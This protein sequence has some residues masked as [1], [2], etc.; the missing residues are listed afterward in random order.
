MIV[1]D[2]AHIITSTLTNLL[3][4]IRFD[5]WVIS[6]TGSTDNTK[7]LITEFFQKEGIPGTL[8]DTPWTDFG[9]NRTAVLDAAF[10]KA[11]YGLM[12]DA[13]DDIKGDFRLPNPLTMDWYNLQY[14]YGT[15][16][17]LTRPQLFNLRKRWRY[18]GVLHEY[19]EPVD[20]VG[21]CSTI[22]GPYYFTL[23]YRGNRS[24]DADKYI[25]DAITLELAF[26]KTEPKNPLHSRYAY[27]CAQSYHCANV[28]PKAIEY[29]KKT[30][31]LNGWSEEKYVSSFRLYDL[32]DNKMT[33][34]FYL[35]DALKYNPKRIECVYRLVKH[36]TLKK[37]HAKALEYYRTIQ[38]AYEVDFDRD[39]LTGCV[40]SVNTLEYTFYLPY[41]MIIVSDRTKQTEIGARM[42]EI[43]G[44]HKVTDID[45]FHATHVFHNFRFFA[46]KVAPAVFSAL[47]AYA[48]A[49]R[50]SG[51]VIDDAFID[52]ETCSLRS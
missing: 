42:Y 51:K 19:L 28:L 1:K 45:Q 18:V 17:R 36:Y 31:T 43:L 29:Y 14:G 3:H 50:A 37:E 34:L 41:S 40:L 32:A 12:F 46:N 47:K 49:L 9:T 21:P 52:Y 2:E 30:L 20:A 22:T 8:L 10:N 39:G 33:A 26:Y 15:G 23:G 6:D 48:V 16:I 4:Y 35:I 27:Y 25:K 13:D 38:T 44:K 5:T 11:D 24:K 7:A